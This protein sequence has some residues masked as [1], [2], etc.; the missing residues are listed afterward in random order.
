MTDQ[1]PLPPAGYY[2]TPE[3]AMRWWDGTE[4][5]DYYAPTGTTPVIDD[6]DAS[7]AGQQTAVIDTGV[8][9][10]RD[11]TAVISAAGAPGAVDEDTRLSAPDP[12]GHTGDPNDTGDLRVFSSL[13][14]SGT[15]TAAPVGESDAS[16]ERQASA[17]AFGG[18]VPATPPSGEGHPSDSPVNA[19]ESVDPTPEQPAAPRP[20]PTLTVPGFPG[21]SWGTAHSRATIARVLPLTALGITLLGGLLAVIG[22]FAGIRELIATF[23]ILTFFGILVAAAGVW[24]NWRVQEKQWRLFS[25][26]SAGVTVFGPLLLVIFL[27]ATLL[28]LS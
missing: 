11:D 7:S 17:P 8:L 24:A 28:I 6:A 13:R 12:G 21:V 26:L 15:A 10:D 25:W 1:Q 23:V 9:D 27:L 3:G 19:P 16:P 5:T 18:S 4:W 22:A 20:E 2:A 14:E